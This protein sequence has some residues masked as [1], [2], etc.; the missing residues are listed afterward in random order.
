MFYSDFRTVTM[1]NYSTGLILLN[2]LIPLPVQFYV[3][4]VNMRRIF[5]LQR[6]IL[7]AHLV[8]P[9]SFLK[10]LACTVVTTQTRGRK[11]FAAIPTIVP[12]F[13]LKNKIQK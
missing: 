8:A 6:C 2:K 5:L 1:I 12:A 9:E 4:L 10:P 13:T 3:R 11:C 7:V